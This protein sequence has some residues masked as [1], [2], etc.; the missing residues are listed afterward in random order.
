MTNIVQN[1]ETQQ[2]GKKIAGGLA[3][4]ATARLIR[5]WLLESNKNSSQNS[6]ELVLRN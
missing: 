1:R 2:L 5:T 4:K 3:E 6:S